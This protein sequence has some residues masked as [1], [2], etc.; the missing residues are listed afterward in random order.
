MVAYDIVADV[1]VLRKPLWPISLNKHDP[2]G[3]RM[4][5]QFHAKL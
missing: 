1:V 4:V 3:T 2:S 5:N